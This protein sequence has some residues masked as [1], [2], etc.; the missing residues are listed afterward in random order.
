[1]EKTPDGF[2]EERAG[3]GRE[4]RTPISRGGVELALIAAPHAGHNISVWSS[5]VEH[6]GHA[7][8]GI[9]S[10]AAV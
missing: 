1:V 4:A 5:G 6:A 10:D 3:G 7:R 2:G 8:K 9:A